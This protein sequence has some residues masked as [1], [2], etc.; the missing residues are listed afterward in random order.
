MTK[1]VSGPNLQTVARAI[2]GSLPPGT[3]ADAVRRFSGFALS[4]PAAAEAARTLADF[5][6]LLSRIDRAYRA[7]GINNDSHRAGGCAGEGTRKLD[8]VRKRRPR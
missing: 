7:E 4:G 8:R 5:V 3:L 6:T 1:C 2:A